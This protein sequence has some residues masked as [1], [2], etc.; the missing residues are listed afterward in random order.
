MW[1]DLGFVPNSRGNKAAANLRPSSGH[2]ITRWIIRVMSHVPAA[3]QMLLD[4]YLRSLA[5]FHCSVRVTGTGS[6]SAVMLL[7]LA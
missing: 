3:T 2:V 6:L 4:V 7:I 1:C 5:G